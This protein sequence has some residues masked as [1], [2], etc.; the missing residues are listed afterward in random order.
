MVAVF[1]SALTNMAVFL[2]IATMSSLVGRFFKEFGFTV[3]YATLFSLLLSFTLTP[4]LASRM[5][6]RHGTQK[7]ILTWFGKYWEAM[8]GFWERRYANSL[9]IALRFRWLIILAAIV[10]F[11]GSFAS[12]K[13]IGGE[14]LTEADEGEVR[15]AVEK[16]VDES[17]EGTSYTMLLL[18]ERLKTLPYIDRFYTA[19][20]GGEGSTTGVNEGDITVTLVKRDQ[21]TLSTE[22][23]AAKFR[24]LFADIPGVKLTIEPVAS[25][26]GSGDKPVS[27]DIMGQNMDELFAVADQLM[28]ILK[29]TPGAVDVDMNW[30]LGKPEVR[31]TPDYR[32]CADYGITS[33]Q[34]AMM[35]RTSFAGNVGSVYRV[36][37]EEY[38]IRVKLAEEDRTDASAIGALTNPNPERH[39]AP[40]C[41]QQDSICRRSE[42]DLSFGSSAFGHSRSKCG[43]GGECRQYRAKRPGQNG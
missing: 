26:P 6:Q 35:L 29:Q 40:G 15:I 7:G 42:Q 11:V 1:G 22:Q 32:R 16:A 21:R 3:V 30:R 17:L 37:G 9:K 31:V 41:G 14:F 2:P 10:I 23:V 34:L 8:Y 5:L 39:G 4:M 36:S 20:G 18:E 12:L 25:S 27:V 28:E 38:D 13:W 19:M 43:G 33:A 24:H